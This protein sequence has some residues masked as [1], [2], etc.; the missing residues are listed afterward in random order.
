[1]KKLL[2]TSTALL[3][4]GCSSHQQQPPSA[5]P[6][7]SAAVPIV[8]MQYEPNVQ[9]M[10]RN[11]VISAVLTCQSSGLRAEIISGKRMINGY[12]TSIPVDV[13]CIPKMDPYKW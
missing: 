6:F 8:T 13:V 1:M 10:S 3:F 12:V 11:D 4:A 2:I 5:I 9:Q 7:S